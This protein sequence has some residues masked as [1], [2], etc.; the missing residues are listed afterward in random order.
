MAW[1]LRE[2]MIVHS[3]EAGLWNPKGYA[4]NA[5]ARVRFTVVERAVK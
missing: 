3:G 2:D 1:G 4:S 5:W